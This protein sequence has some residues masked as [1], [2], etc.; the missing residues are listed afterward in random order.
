MINF[1][2]QQPI[3]QSMLHI[4]A[5]AVRQMHTHTFIKAVI[6][7]HIHMHTY[8]CTYVRTYTYGTNETNEEFFPARNKQFK[9]RRRKNRAWLSIGQRTQW[10]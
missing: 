3:S 1:E 9:P 10:F 5:N 2:S 8:M 6:E 4:Q 7:V